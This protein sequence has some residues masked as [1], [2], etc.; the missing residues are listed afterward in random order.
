MFSSLVLC[1][2]SCHAT[3]SNLRHH[4]CYDIHWSVH[5]GDPSEFTSKSHY[6]QYMCLT[7][8]SKI[9][10]Y[11]IIHNKG[12]SACVLHGL[13]YN[14][15]TEKRTLSFDFPK[16]STFDENNPIFSRKSVGYLIKKLLFSSLPDPSREHLRLRHC[17]VVYTPR[18]AVPFNTLQNPLPQNI[19]TYPDSFPAVYFTTR[20]PTLPALCV[21]FHLRPDIMSSIVL[22]WDVISGFGNVATRFSKICES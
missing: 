7:S 15:F 3:G 6:I 20:P 11:F 12:I 22:D 17:R 5:S 13:K 18:V 4:H 9:S 1:N 2:I 8:E 16:G 14:V 21:V 10:F 19:G